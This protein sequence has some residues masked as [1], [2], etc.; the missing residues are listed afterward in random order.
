MSTQKSVTIAQVG[1]VVLKRS[2]RARNLSIRIKPFEGIQVSV[3]RGMSF[4]QAENLVRTKKDWIAKNLL[5]VLAHEQRA[6]IYDGSKA[7]KTRA[8][9]LVVLPWT[10]DSVDV[11]VTH[12]RALVRYPEALEVANEAVQVGIRKALIEA[13]RREAK[14]YLPQQ[15][16]ALAK[17]F[18]FKF[19]R[20]FIKNHRSRWGSCSGADNINLSL[21]LMRLPDELINY[22]ILHELVHTEIKNHSS[23]FWQRLTEVCPNCLK[24][25]KQLRQFEMP[26]PLG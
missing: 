26:F 6:A 13:Y 21:H 22:V 17:K 25:R 18:G 12:G 23:K 19:K 5:K 16:K 8:H 24:L 7:I 4:S 11:R 9:C 14:D 3:P 20:V 15:T 2:V 1:P 10:K